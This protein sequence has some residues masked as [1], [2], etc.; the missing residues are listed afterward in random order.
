MIYAVAKRRDM[1]SIARLFV[2]SFAERLGHAG[3]RLPAPVLIEQALRLFYDA[4]PRSFLVAQ[5]G[6]DI[7]G[8]AFAPHPR[9]ALW[10]AAVVRGHALRWLWQWPVIWRPAGLSPLRL[11]IT[12]QGQGRIPAVLWR[13]RDPGEARLLLAAVRPDL[14]GQGVGTNLVRHA[15]AAWRHRGVARVRLPIPVDDEGARRLLSKAGFREAA[16]GRGLR[17]WSVMEREL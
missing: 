2:E 17:R 10:R 14:R 15:L 4:D 16:E 13:S 7:A 11:M 5:Q 8:Y 12:V 6:P 9:S 3:A 1:G